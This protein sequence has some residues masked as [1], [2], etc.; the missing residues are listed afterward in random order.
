[1]AGIW[2]EFGREQDEI[3][4]IDGGLNGGL[5]VLLIG[6]TIG[7]Q[8]AF[9]ADHVA[10]VSSIA[11]PRSS[12]RRIVAHGAL[13]GLGHTLTLMVV[14]GGA[15]VFGLNIDPSLAVWLEI[16][17][18]AM[19]I[20]LGGQV[21]FTMVRNRIHFHRH[22]HQDGAV[23]FHAHSHLGETDQHNPRQHD[24]GH[25]PRLP[26]RALFVGIMHGLAGSAALLVLT[27]TTVG[28][29]ILGIGYILLFGLG[30][31]LGMASL[32]AVIA[33]P[34]SWSA[35]AITWANNALQG[36][37]G[38]ATV[39]LGVFVVVDNLPTVMV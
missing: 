36:A 14:A 22:A 17:V 29:T 8:H 31:I 28:S 5:S 7:M 27:A 18:G 15:V 23:H 39:A 11:A 38:S 16:F 4:M 34:L 35:K 10:A 20:C 1:L 13:W 32:S 24:H 30:S 33:I 37:I 9:E 6:L 21:V 26:I 12:V 3:K 19:L 2:P 25:A